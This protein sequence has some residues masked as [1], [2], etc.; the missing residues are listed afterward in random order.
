MR[1]GIQYTLRTYSF[2][3]QIEFSGIYNV[4]LVETYHNN[5]GERYVEFYINTAI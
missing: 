1:L 3:T 5:P 2:K 4:G